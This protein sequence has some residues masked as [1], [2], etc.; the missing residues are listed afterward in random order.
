MVV[1]GEIVV[2]P[3]GEGTSVSKYVRAAILKLKGEGFRVFPHP[4]G[5]V[6]EADNL[7]DVLR[8][9]EVAHNAVLAASAKRV[10]TFVKIDERKDKELSVK[11]I[12]QTIEDIR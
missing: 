9:V 7:K 5:T 8:A 6:V 3:I 10:W 1:V 11:Q 12:L 4:W 2:A